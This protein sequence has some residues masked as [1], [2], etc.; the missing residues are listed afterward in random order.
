[1]ETMEHSKTVALEAETKPTSE[2]HIQLVTEAERS[3]P[4][5]SILIQLS[6]VSYLRAQSAHYT[7]FDHR[8]LSVYRKKFGRKAK[9]YWIDLALID[10]TPH[11]FV[12]SDRHSL[13]TS[14]GMLGLCAIL[15]LAS[16]FSRMPWYAHTWSPL[17]MLSLSAAVIA[18]LVFVHRSQNLVRF[19]SQNGD[20]MLLEMFN[21][22]PNRKE[23]SAFARELVQHI[24]AAQKGDKR[25]LDQKLGAE[26]REHRRL[27]DQGILSEEAYAGARDKILRRHRQSQVKPSTTPPPARPEPEESDIIEVT[28]SNGK[29]QT[30]VADF[31][32]FESAKKSA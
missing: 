4:R 1:M 13:Y 10:S 17:T 18:L 27:K 16:V 15:T 20:A 12:K 14:G 9:Q 25:K 29:W 30:T 3:A 11:F 24:Q 2:E 21:N 8:F 32:L 7:I 31:D 23:F 5:P 19:H 6:Q 28:V 26:L 22:A